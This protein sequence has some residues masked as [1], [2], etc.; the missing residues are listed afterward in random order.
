MTSRTRYTPTPAAPLPSEHRALL[1]AHYSLQNHQQHAL[2]ALS[3]APASAPTPTPTSH[4]PPST[5]PYDAALSTPSSKVQQGPTNGATWPSELRYSR[6]RR[7]N[8]D[9]P[10][11][12][13]GGGGGGGGRKLATGPASTQTPHALNRAH[14]TANTQLWVAVACVP[15]RVPCF[16]L[17]SVLCT[18]WTWT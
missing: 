14:R 4:A 8:R 5:V 7:R 6:W 11:V 13:C 3:L 10:S 2:S 12:V 15:P 16:L 1:A 9:R 17:C 18:T